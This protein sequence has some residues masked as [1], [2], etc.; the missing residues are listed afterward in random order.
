MS[1]DQQLHNYRSNDH[2]RGYAISLL[3]NDEYRAPELILATKPLHALSATAPDVGVRA[4]LIKANER[5][6]TISPKCA[7]G[8]QATD[9]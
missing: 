5:I 2:N 4:R 9:T 3:V 6:S 8:E 7:D 1:L